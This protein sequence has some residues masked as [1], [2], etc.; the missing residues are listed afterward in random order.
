M[1]P[2]G[3]IDPNGTRTVAIRAGTSSPNSCQ[4]RRAISR[5]V[6]GFVWA[7]APAAPPAKAAAIAIAVATKN[8]RDL[9]MFVASSLPPS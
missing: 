7:A 4:Q 9:I 3:S 1:T 6:G 8:R 5:V 2:W